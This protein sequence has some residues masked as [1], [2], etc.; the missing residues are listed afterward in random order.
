MQRFF[1]DSVQ[2]D[3]TKA[4]QQYIRPLCIIGVPSLGRMPVVKMEFMDT[5]KPILL[6]AGYTLSEMQT[7]TNE[8][9]FYSVN[10]YAL[11]HMIQSIIRS[12]LP[13]NIDPET[14]TYLQARYDE[15]GGADF[16]I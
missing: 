7:Q 1:K 9:T 6:S 5:F 12:E 4:S 10:A 14:P 13:F 15:N 3:I 2:I 16:K 8:F 11:E